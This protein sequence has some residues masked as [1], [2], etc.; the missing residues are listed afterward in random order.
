MTSSRMPNLLEPISLAVKWNN[1]C[2]TWWLNTEVSISIFPPSVVIETSVSKS[3]EHAPK[4]IYISYKCNTA[5]QL[6]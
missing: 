5:T 4:Y 3:V 1:H 6:T 2:L